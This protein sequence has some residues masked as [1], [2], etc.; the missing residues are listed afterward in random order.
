MKVVTPLS[1]LLL[2]LTTIAFIIPKKRT[3]ISCGTT[4]AVASSSSSFHVLRAKRNKNRGDEDD[5]NR[6]YDDVDEDA[7]PDKVFWQEMERQR[8]LN[9]VGEGSETT[10]SGMNGG[11]GGTSISSGLF[12]GSGGYGGMTGIIGTSLSSTTM[13][14]ITNPALDQLRSSTSSQ[15]PQPPQIQ[16]QPPFRRMQPL[17]TMEQ[18]KIA[19][20]TLAE[21]ELYAVK[22]NWIDETLQIQEM[23]PVNITLIL[24][25]G[26]EQEKQQQEQKQQDDNNHNPEAT[27]TA[28]TVSKRLQ[29]DEEPWDYFG[30]ESTSKDDDRR[31]RNVMKVPFP[32]KGKIIHRK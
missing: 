12:G 30:D 17:P 6:W 1:L 13:G 21:Y 14:P 25:E 8:L 15:L 10:T 32:P 28:T 18:I 26:D 24:L 9:Q 27:A 29:I 16:S 11:S 4:T 22:D 5:L 23:D 20:A 31:R 7:T 19:D 2:P 3:T